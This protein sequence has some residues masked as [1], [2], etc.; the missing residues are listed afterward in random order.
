MRLK[1]FVYQPLSVRTYLV[2]DPTT[3]ECAVIDPVRVAAPVADYIK[4]QNLTLKAVLETHVHA[5]FVSGAKEL[6]H[7]FQGQPKIYCSVEG[8]KA[9]LPKYADVAVHNGDDISIGQVKLKALHTPGHTPEHL[10]WLCYEGEALI[11]AFTGD[12]LLIGGVGRPDLLGD[13]MTETLLSEL[14]RSL[15]ER[16]SHL[17]DSL[18]IYPA[19]GPGSLCSKSIASGDS[20]TLGTERQTNPA[21]QWHDKDLWAREL[22][23]DVPAKPETFTRNKKINI[24]GAC[25]IDELSTADPESVGDNQMANTIYDFRS[26]ID[27]GEAHRTGAINVPL[28]SPSTGSWLAGVYRGEN[29]IT[30]II[31]SVE[32]K[33]F[34][35]NLFSVLAGNLEVTFNVWDHSKEVNPLSTLPALKPN[36]LHGLVQNAGA[37]VFIVDVRTPQEWEEGHLENAMHIELFK[38][39]DSAALDEIPR[40]AKIVTMCRSGMRSSIAASILLNKGFKN[41][42][43]LHG[44]INEWR[45]A[46]L[47][48]VKS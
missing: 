14:H 39:A 40:N 5:D 13:E 46:H 38:L 22:Q 30:A 15:F 1:T 3:Q 17:P 45:D 21:F 8:G 33:E 2:I 19:H 32:D 12:F 29:A 37:N 11:A 25:L 20:S 24:E 7:L 35:R 23:K 34:V 27:F 36:D 9:W 6:K 48:V 10:T 4:S 47:P 16:I 42:S 41:V 26:P 18:T 44:G 28:G 31:P 43:H